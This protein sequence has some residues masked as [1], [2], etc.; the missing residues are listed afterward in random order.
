VTPEKHG[1]VGLQQDVE[2]IALRA[3]AR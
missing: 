2:R 1:P 3:G